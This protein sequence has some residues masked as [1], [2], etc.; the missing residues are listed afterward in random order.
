[1]LVKWVIPFSRALG[2]ERAERALLSVSDG[3]GARSRPQEQV[4]G[5]PP[6][7]FLLGPTT[8]SCHALFWED[9]GCLVRPALPF[10]HCFGLP[11]LV[12]VVVVVVEVIVVRTEVWEERSIGDA[13]RKVGEENTMIVVVSPAL[14]GSKRRRGFVAEPPVCERVRSSCAHRHGTLPSAP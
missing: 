2:R 1:M 14:L 8:S 10:R 6:L 11:L 3:L 4:S 7:V 12:V 9:S 13:E 5:N